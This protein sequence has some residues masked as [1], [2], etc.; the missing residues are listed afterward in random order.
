MTVSRPSDR[1]SWDAWTRGSGSRHEATTD[2]GPLQ[3]REPAQG[4]D[5]Q[6]HHQSHSVREEGCFPLSSGTLLLG[7]DGLA[8]GSH[9]EGGS[10]S[11]PDP[12]TSFCPPS[13]WSS[14][15]PPVRRRAY[16]RLLLNWTCYGVPAQPTAFSPRI[17]SRERGPWRDRILLP[18]ACGH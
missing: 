5:S 11:N 10:G 9:V 1:L 14:V 17:P 3:P 4:G 8:G 6:R 16:L 2:T 7:H 12:P 13:L 15:F 18:M